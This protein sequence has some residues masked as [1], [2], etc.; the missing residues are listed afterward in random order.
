MTPSKDEV[1]LRVLL[2]LP[3]SILSRPF[4]STMTSG[5]GSI[6]APV[7]KEAPER[8]TGKVSDNERS[9]SLSP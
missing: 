3:C 2:P 6:T 4:E 8:S 9:T 5:F 7:S 1:E